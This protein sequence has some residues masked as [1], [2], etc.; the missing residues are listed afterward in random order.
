[1]HMKTFLIIL[2]NVLK[3]DHPEID[4]GFYVSR[5]SK[6]VHMGSDVPLN[7]IK[8]IQDILLKIENLWLVKKK[9]DK[10]S[11]CEPYMISSTKWK[12]DYIIF[13]KNYDYEE[14]SFAEQIIF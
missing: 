4:L 1:M 9:D 6:F 7:K 3:K 5:R 12:Y 10:F 11:Y 8:N 13:R 14:L 2:D